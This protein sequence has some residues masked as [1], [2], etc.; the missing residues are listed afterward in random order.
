MASGDVEPLI[1]D[2]NNDL[3]PLWTPTGDRLLFL[4]DRSGLMGLWT[5]GVENGDTV[6]APVMVKPD[7]EQ[8]IPLGVARDGSLFY[9]VRLGGANVYVTEIDTDSGALLAPSRQ[10]SLLN[11]GSNL[12]P[13]WSPDG[14]KLAFVTRQGWLRLESST[15][16]LTILDVEN[17]DIRVL[18]PDLGVFRSPTWTGDGRAVR[19]AGW[20]LE[21]SPGLYEIDVETAQVTTLW[22]MSEFVGV[23]WAPDGTRVY[24]ER[25]NLMVRDIVTGAEAELYDGG[26]GG[27]R[28]SRDGTRL[29]FRYDED[30]V[31]G[32]MVLSVDGLHRNRLTRWQ[33]QE[34]LGQ[35]WDWTPDGAGVIWE[36][37]PDSPDGAKMWYVPVNGSPR[38]ELA[39]DPADGQNFRFHPDGRRLAFTGGEQR[40]E[41][42]VIQNFLADRVP[43]P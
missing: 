26:V 39:V 33:G 24:F 8:T 32:I 14:T 29:A 5:I 27:L 9:T 6:C 20:D 7:M 22:R 30:D 35:L 31:R 42:W 17:G 4:S 12:Q 13:D 21:G 41:V 28:I 40:H 15:D 34:W 1:S 11:V 23:Q 25:D 19:V 18:E 2:P 37:A 38:R 10:I 43:R 16:R 3:Y 36:S